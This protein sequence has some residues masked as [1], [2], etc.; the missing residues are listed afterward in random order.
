[1][2]RLLCTIAALVLMISSASAICG[3]WGWG[4]I[5]PPP[6]ASTPEVIEYV[7]SVFDYY[8]EYDCYHCGD[9]DTTFQ[10]VY[11]W[12]CCSDIDPLLEQ[13]N[14][15]IIPMD[16]DAAWIEANADYWN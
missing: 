6:N 1:M 8:E 3:N 4:D 13:V 16:A 15:G 9:V 12:T 2:K 5:P 10:N 11:H 7:Q 14:W